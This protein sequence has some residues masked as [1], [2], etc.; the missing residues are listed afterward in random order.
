MIQ[1]RPILFALGLILCTIAAAMLLPAMIDVADGHDD[2]QVFLA[3]ATATFFFG[4]LLVLVTYDDA[5]PRVGIKEAFLLTTLSWVV[6]TGFAALPFLGL[7]LSFT[8]AYFETMSGLTTTGSTVLVGLD[9]LPRGVLLWRALLNGLGG[10]GIIV[11]A[12]ILL[13][14]LRVGG[15]QLFQAENSDRSEKVLPRAVELSMAIAGI[16]VGLI[17]LAAIVFALLGMTPFDAICHALAAVATGGFSTH[18]ASFGFFRSA[19]IE[20]AAVVFMLLGALPFVIFIKALRGSPSSLVKD[21]QIRGFLL[22]V[23]AVSVIMAIWLTTVR[24]IPFAEALRLSAFNVTSI[25]TTTGFVSA[26]YTTWGPFAVGVFFLLTFV[27]GCA[28]ST[29]GGIKVYR[30]QVAGLLTRSHFVHLMSPNRI[31]TLVYNGRRLPADVP[32]SVVAF[33]AIYMATVGIFTVIL[34]AMGLDLVTSLSSAA[35]AVGNVGPGLGDIVG[36]AGNFS[37]L[38]AGAKWVLSFAM[39]LG[40]LELFTVLVLFRVEFWRS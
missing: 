33:L 16:Y 2:W 10:L 6:V 38:P 5:P 13:P 17:V 31:V 18:D 28:G 8:D 24:G 39:M 12:I 30:L 3:S 27:G 14:F 21:E 15:M 40:R 35:Q 36:P 19:P 9:K 7:G 1:F 4:G 20:W 25:V 23:A 11:I 37:T 26:D 22:F 32:F 34:T 29:A